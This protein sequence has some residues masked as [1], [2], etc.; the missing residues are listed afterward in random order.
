M[1]ALAALARVAPLLASRGHRWGPGG[2]V[3][4][5]IATGVAT[6]TSSSDLDLILRQEHRLGLDEAIDLRAVLVGAAAPARVDVL[7]E[8]P[9]G[10]VSLADLAAMPAR[11]LVRTP[12]G[13]RLLADPW[14]AGA[15]SVGGCVM[16][17]A[18]LFPG[19]G[20]Q[21]RGLLHHLPQHAEVTRTI[22]EA[23][24]LLGVDI[25][26]LDNSEALHS[27][28]AVQPALLIAGV[29]TARSLMAEDVHPASVAGMSIGAFG[30]AV[31]CGT[32]SFTDALRV[33][34]LRGE[35]MQDAFPSGYG[36]AA[37]E[38][39]N[40][41]Q[42][43]RI[44]EQIRTA[45]IPVYVSNINAPRQIVV[46][47]SDRALDAATAQARQ[48]GARRA[49][50]LTV[51]VP[52]HC[53]LLQPVADRLQQLMAGLALRPPSMPYVSNCGGRPLYDAEAIRQDLATGVAHPVRWY[54]TL[55]VMR[56]L[57]ANV[58]IEMAPG[59]VSTHLVAELFPDVRAVSIADHGLRYATVL[60]ARERGE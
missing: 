59:H 7:L 30:A 35:L 26:D 2:S 36:L 31:T 8:T 15:C 10:G 19:Q 24:T 34:R 28:A 44:T 47:G 4:F 41:V 17:I 9:C 57:G 16:T 25:A 6:A 42:V 54:D 48:Q 49:E 18:F 37:I 39:L 29:A 32:L 60:A 56:E 12:D 50:R 14:K 58:F 52:S 53:P 1:P 20:A 21:S 43:E 23:S 55:E 40:E 5:E 51:S 13:P 27:T 38:G 33:V 22:E 11:L 46:A 45:E 3:G